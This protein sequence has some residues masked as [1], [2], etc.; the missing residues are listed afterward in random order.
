M[1]ILFVIML[2]VWLVALIASGFGGLIHSVVTL[3]RSEVRS[4]RISSTEPAPGSR[5]VY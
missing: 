4:V 1:W 5:A 3:C 2:A